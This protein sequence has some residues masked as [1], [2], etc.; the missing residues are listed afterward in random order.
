MEVPEEQLAHLKRLAAAL[1]QQSCTAEVVRAAS[2]PY[3]MVASTSDPTLN[4]RVHCR[5][6]GDGS[7]VFEWPWRQPIGPV[8]GLETVAGKI[9]EVLRPV[10][11]GP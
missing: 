4:E 11:G 3:L 6:A 1:H 9:A 2:G 5:R 7:W 10:V 8:D